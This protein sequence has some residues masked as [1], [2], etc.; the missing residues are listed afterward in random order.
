MFTDRRKSCWSE[1]QPNQLP[2]P[3][4]KTTQPKTC[5][6]IFCFVFMYQLEVGF[7]SFLG[8]LDGMKNS[9]VNGPGT[10]RDDLPPVSGTGDMGAYNLP[11]QDNVS[12]IS[13]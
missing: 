10:P 5:E 2:L 9:P 3:T 8:D 11:Y 6:Q 1:I 12:Q 4:I 7:V 13:L